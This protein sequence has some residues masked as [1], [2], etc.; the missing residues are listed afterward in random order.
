[1]VENGV[2]GDQDDTN[3]Q[4]IHVIKDDRGGCKYVDADHIGKNGDHFVHNIEMVM[5]S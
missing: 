5:F 2:R 1:M 3:H 4:N